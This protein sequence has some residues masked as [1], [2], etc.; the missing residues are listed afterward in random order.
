[1][2]DICGDEVLFCFGLIA[3]DFRKRGEEVPERLW[4]FLNGNEFLKSEA[5]A[6]IDELKMGGKWG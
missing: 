1:M 4:W 5:E 2:S 3:D 6:I